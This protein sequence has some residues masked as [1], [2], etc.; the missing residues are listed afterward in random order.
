MTILF[1]ITPSFSKGLLNFAKVLNLLGSCSENHSA[2]SPSK[3]TQKGFH[4]DILLIMTITPPFFYGESC[5]S[6]AALLLDMITSKL[7]S[8][9]DINKLYKLYKLYKFT[10]LHGLARPNHFARC[11]KNKS[12][13]NKMT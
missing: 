10:I 8:Y 11:R 7:K 9:K 6:L 5:I 2:A 13:E 3:N 12:K 1:L 4:L